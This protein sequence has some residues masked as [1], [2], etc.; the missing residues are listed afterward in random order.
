MTSYPWHMRR[1]SPKQ[2]R[3]RSKAYKASMADEECWVCGKRDGTVVGAHKRRG[4]T[5]GT[6]LKPGDHLIAPL[7]AEHH[8]MEHSGKEASDWVW[9]KVL[10]HLLW[11]H[12]KEFSNA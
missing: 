11:V 4:Q 7:C 3:P 9:D 1:A 2:D 10:E 5:G 8:A 6:G 12:F